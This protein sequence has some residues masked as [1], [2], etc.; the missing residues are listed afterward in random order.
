MVNGFTKKTYIAM[1]EGAKKEAIKHKM[2][3]K[4]DWDIGIIDLKKAAGKDGVFCYT[5]FKVVANI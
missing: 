5:F 1:V 3:T 2:I 4:K